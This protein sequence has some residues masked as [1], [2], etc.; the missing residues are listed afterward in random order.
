[1]NINTHVRPLQR[2]A[3]FSHTTPVEP[4]PYCSYAEA[5]NPLLVI[6]HC[7]AAL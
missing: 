1:M 7:Q 5:A 4:P 6:G 3:Y 2:T